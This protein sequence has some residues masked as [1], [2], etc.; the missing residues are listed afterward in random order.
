MKAAEYA[1]YSTD[2]QQHNSI[3]YQ[4]SEIRRYC[5][6]NNITITATFIDE[7]E[8]GTNTN[9]YGNL[10]RSQRA[11]DVPGIDVIFLGPYD[12]SQALGVPG[13][14]KHPLMLDA[15]KRILNKEAAV[16]IKPHPHG[17]FQNVIRCKAYEDRNQNG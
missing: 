7:A 3:E 6:E 11:F 15:E 14:I 10:M 8:S 4:L 9:R 16:V 1:R 13:Q 12:M 2:R 17:V 5:A